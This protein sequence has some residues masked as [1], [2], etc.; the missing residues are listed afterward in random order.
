MTPHL[1]IPLKGSTSGRQYAGWEP[2]A[3][4]TQGLS[5]RALTGQRIPV[6]DGVTLNA[7][8]YTP[9]TPGRYPAVVSFAAYSSESH[10]AGI[11]TGTNEAGSLPVFTDRGYCSVIVERRGMGRSSGKPVPAVPWPDRR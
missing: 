1:T 11:P 10:T 3:V 2:R 9:R 8:V 5:N 6:D 4:A 7:D